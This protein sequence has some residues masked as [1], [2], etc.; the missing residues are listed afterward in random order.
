MSKVKLNSIE[1]KEYNSHVLN[2]IPTLLPGTYYFRDFFKDQATSARIA[3]KFY[4]DVCDNLFPRVSLVGQL[5]R[6]GYLVS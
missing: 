4:E 6:E 5:S 1:T 2:K 3:R